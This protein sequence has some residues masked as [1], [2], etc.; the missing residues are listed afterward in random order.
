[1][2]TGCSSYVVAA[3][4]PRTTILIDRE[5]R[6]LDEDGAEDVAV[7]GTAEGRCSMTI[8][9]GKWTSDWYV[10]RE[11]F[12]AYE[13]SRKDDLCIICLGDPATPGGY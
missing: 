6:T 8:D 12:A 3:I 5:S 9:A 10:G 2:N 11:I 7:S 4:P 1:M 13:D